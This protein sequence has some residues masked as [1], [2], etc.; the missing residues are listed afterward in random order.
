MATGDWILFLGADDRLAS[1]DVIARAGIVLAQALPGHRVVYGQVDLVGANGEVVG[2]LHRPWSP[3][4]FYGC[5]YNLP[6]QAVFHHR[7]LFTEFG[8]FD[9]SLKIAAAFDFLLRALAHSEPLFMPGLTVTRMQI[10]GLSNNRLNAPAL[11]WEEL[12][13]YRRHVGSVPWLH[14]W[15]LA[16][17]WVKYALCRIGGDRLALNTT[18]LYRKLMRG[19]GPLRY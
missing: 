10:G 16:K 18:N 11:V 2:N 1:P 15:W 5:R 12:R 9:T 7:S 17:A 14:L 13:L 4:E 8:P 19:E 3:P 6:H